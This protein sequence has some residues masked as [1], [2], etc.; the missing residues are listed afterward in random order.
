VQHP[1][2]RIGGCQIIGKQARAV[3]GIVVD[4]QHIGFGRRAVN[5]RDQFREILALVVRAKRD[6][7]P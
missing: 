3:G 6:Q 2:A 4:D 7:E 1:H 5:F